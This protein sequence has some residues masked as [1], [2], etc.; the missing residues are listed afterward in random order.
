MGPWPITTAVSSGCARALYHRL[1]TSVYRFDKTGAFER[2]TVRNSFHT[3]LDD[4]VHNPYIL[5][6]TAAGRLKS[7]SDP[8]FLVDRTLRVEFPLAVE[9]VPARNVVKHDYAVTRCKAAHL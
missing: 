7:G 3:V 4:P 6:E 1:Q 8:D 5:R 2:N 9:A